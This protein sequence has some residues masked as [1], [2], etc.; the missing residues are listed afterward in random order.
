M[1]KM[2]IKA[3]IPQLKIGVNFPN[4][5]LNKQISVKKI[6]MLGINSPSGTRA[7]ILIKMRSEANIGAE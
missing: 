3:N 6:Q 5:Y 2:R 7:F 1:I 4:T